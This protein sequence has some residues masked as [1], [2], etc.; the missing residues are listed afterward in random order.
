MADDRFSRPVT[1]VDT[2]HD[3]PHEVEFFRAI[4]AARHGGRERGEPHTA[5][6]RPPRRRTSAGP[7]PAPRDNEPRTV[8]SKLDVTA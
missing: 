3:R 5:P 2:L 6:P 1:G 7:A 4:E 8:G